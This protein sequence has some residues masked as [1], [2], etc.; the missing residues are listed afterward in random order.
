MV[1]L[2]FR[3]VYINDF[4]S[5]V[6]NNEKRGNIIKPDLTIDN[7][8]YG[9]K[10]FEL[11]QIRMQTEVIHNLLSK[12]NLIDQDIDLIIGGD[13]LN[14][15]TGTTYSVKN[16]NISFLGVYSACS[17]FIESLIIGSRFLECDN[18]KKIMCLTSSHNLSAE[19]QFRYPVEYGAI[20]NVNSTFT[21]T[22]AISCLLSTKRG[23][24]KI[25]NATI[26]SIF[27]YDIKDPNFIG[28]IMAPSAAEVIVEHLN[29]FN[30]DI[31]YYDLILTGDLG[32]VGLNILKDYLNEEFHIIANNII[33]AGSMLYKDIPDINDGASG[34]FSLP[35]YFFYNIFRKKKYRK[36]LLVGTGALHSSTLVNQ[37]QSIPSIS[38]AVGLEILL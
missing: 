7:Y 13:L 21:A 25:K 8:Y 27:D 37:K 31:N 24:I 18:I 16:F 14:Q 23:L 26:G 34:P 1:S 3:N 2:S 4:F 12:N 6:G 10:T 20:R 15:I 32:N 22:G 9:E 5:I 35:L 28:A 11:S 17:S 30:I 33:D 29:N 36:V 19:R 38:H